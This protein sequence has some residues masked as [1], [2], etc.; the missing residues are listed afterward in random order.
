MIRTA[1]IILRLLM[2]VCALAQE[3]IRSFYLWDSSQYRGVTHTLRLEP[4]SLIKMSMAVF[5]D[6]YSG[7]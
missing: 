2:P 6:I 7:K 3:I 5:I 4:H 1:R